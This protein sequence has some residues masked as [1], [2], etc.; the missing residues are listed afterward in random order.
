MKEQR[1]NDFLRLIAEI[2][3]N[4]VVIDSNLVYSNLITLGTNKT[5]IENYFTTWQNRFA[6]NPNIDVF[7]QPDWKCFCQFKGKGMNPQPDTELKIYIPLDESHVYHGVN[8]IFDYISKN[9]IPHKSKV[10]KHTRFDDLV[11]RVDSV[12]ALAAIRRF[13]ET[14]QYIREG[15]IEINPFAITDGLISFAWD[16]TMS[17]NRVVSEWI[18][19]YINSMKDNLDFVS[20]SSFL[21]YIAIRYN[22]V[23][24]NG[25]GI[26]S[27]YSDRKMD[28]TVS[29]L[30]TYQRITELLMISLRSESKLLDLYKFYEFIKDPTTKEEA[31]DNISRLKRKDSLNVEEIP[32]DVR[33]AF[34]YAFLEISKKETPETAVLRFK[35]FSKEGNYD[36]FT[37]SN[38]VRTLMQEMLTMPLADRLIYEEEKQVLINA[39]LNTLEKY[40]SIQLGRALFGIES[41]D[42]NGF[43]NNE[44]AREKLML[45]VEP[46]EIKGVVHKIL[47]EEGYIDLKPNEE[48]W[49]FMELMSK[50]KDKRK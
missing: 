19:E 33:E 50:L 6:N 28:N 31:F 12:N 34:D 38:G 24:Q 18:S 49:I 37:R 30:V 22:E 20:Y 36:L 35:R 45:W 41:G 46:K 1:I 48:Y 5:S 4:G 23:F 40:D 29:D 17:Y 10:G 16:S 11:I 9:R 27:F 3:K 8:K 43:T 15:L 21:E 39:S 7:V 42:Y 26:N 32:I 25:V 14:D 13:A 47:E 44:G 2:S